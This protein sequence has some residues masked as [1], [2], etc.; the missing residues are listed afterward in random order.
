MN[1]SDLEP[2]P[3]KDVPPA[4]RTG[5]AD[6]Y[7]SDHD[8]ADYVWRIMS[9]AS[10]PWLDSFEALL[11]CP[12]PPS[13]RSLIRRYVFADFEVGP[14][15]LPANTGEPLFY[16]LSTFFV[17]DAHLFGTLIQNGFLPFARPD[18]GCYDPICF[19]TKRKLTHGEFPIVR[20]EHEAI[21]CFD[22]IG[23]V[24]D[25]APSFLDF[26]INSVEEC[27]YDYS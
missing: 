7:P 8:D 16:E 6:G 9:A 22:R 17:K 21:L 10:T 20:V 3:G 1:R 4:L 13:F 23:S 11:P 5:Y 18:T 27:V 25:V 24:W 15:W 2:H 19:D 12:F 14:L 26:V